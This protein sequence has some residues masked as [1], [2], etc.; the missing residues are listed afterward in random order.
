M[1]NPV[2]TK[3]PEIG[4][5]VTECGK[6]FPVEL[7]VE[8]FEETRL[9]V[10]FEFVSP[11]GPCGFQGFSRNRDANTLP[12]KEQRV[13]KLDSAGE[14]PMTFNLRI[15]CREEDTFMPRIRIVAVNQHDETDTKFTNVTVEC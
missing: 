5:L 10:I 8:V 2:I 9:T 1:P 7:K 13:R 4:E 6:R 15:T 12:R 3:Y 11:E 14:Y